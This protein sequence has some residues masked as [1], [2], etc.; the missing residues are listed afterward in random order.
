[1][2]QA[3]S[4]LLL[5]AFSAVTIHG[6]PLGIRSK[7]PVDVS[8]LQLTGG[9]DPLFGQQG[10]GPAEGAGIPGGGA[11]F[12]PNQGTGATLHALQ[13]PGP[14]CPQAPPAQQAAPGSFTG[15]QSSAP[16]TTGYEDSCYEGQQAPDQQPCITGDEP[17]C[18]ADEQAPGRQA[19]CVTG[20]EPGCQT[21]LA[22]I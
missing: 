8:K 5:L 19:T 2:V 6:A 18:P 10:T 15:Q 21:P 20:D 11:S 22:A 4:F 13:A 3:C 9:S 12:G 7:D 1:M 17:S 14:S 16:C